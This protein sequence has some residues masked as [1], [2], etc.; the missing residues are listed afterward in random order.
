MKKLLCVLLVLCMAFM[1]SVTAMAEYEQGSARDEFGD[2]VSLVKPQNLKDFVNTALSSDGRFL[3]TDYAE[4][5]C[6]K[7]SVKVGQPVLLKAQS[8]DGEYSFSHWETAGGTFLSENPTLEYTFKSGERLNAVYKT[9]LLWDLNFED[10]R[11]TVPTDRQNIMQVVSVDGNRVMQYAPT[12]T[13]AITWFTYMGNDQNNVY[14]MTRLKA[15][16]DYEFTFDYYIEN[17]GSNPDDIL[18]IAPHNDFVKQTTPIIRLS[19]ETGRWTRWMPMYFRTDST[20]GAG[21]SDISDGLFQICAGKDFRIYIDNVRLKKVTV[22]DNTAAENP[23]TIS[24]YATYGNFIKLPSNLSVA[25]LR[26]A[27][28]KPY[29]VCVSSAGVE[30]EPNDSLNNGMK[31]QN[32]DDEK[33]VAIDGDLNKDGKVSVT[34]IVSAVDAILKGT[35]DEE[36]VFLSDQ[37]RDDRLSVT[38]LVS[39]RAQILNPNDAPPFKTDESV[40]YPILKYLDYLTVN[41]RYSEYMSGISFY[42]GGMSLEFS[43]YCKGD[44]KVRLL[45]GKSNSRF[46]VYVDGNRVADLAMPENNG[47]L[48]LSKG[49]K[50]GFH[51]FKVALQDETSNNVVNLGELKIEGQLLPHKTVDQRLK[52][53]VIGDSITAGCG[54]L[55]P[56]YRGNGAA[57][58]YAYKTAE[59]LGARLS[60]FA[61]GGRTLCPAP[62]RESIAQLYPYLQPWYGRT[63]NTDTYNTK[64]YDFKEKAD[65]IV[66]NLGTN[67]RTSEVG[68]ETYAENMRSFLKTLKEKNLQSKIVWC[69]GMMYTGDMDYSETI[70]AVL[71]EFGGSEKGY[72]ACALPYDRGGVYTY[73][74]KD[75]NTR[76]VPSV[77]EK[78][79]YYSHPNTEGHAAAAEVLTAFLKEQ[80]LKK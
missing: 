31:I 32:G 41:G 24:R 44:V 58:T 19:G 12:S 74:D 1:D 79:H 9:D 15:N 30:N 28:K 71:S 3:K 8:T 62:G 33:T 64:A 50:E 73:T 59:A 43:A 47:D 4:I 78:D 13:W 63:R 46:A 29:A 36:T 25:A 76:S 61:V 48:Y 7:T 6:S 14:R 22:T 66:V 80:V 16:T 20:V 69:Y 40:T 26:M 52:I 38:D 11:I 56:G 67:D 77:S 70:V 18:G 2:E 53:E 37:N 49:L 17:A 45:S 65:V 68:E 42:Y 23:E 60:T 10:N 5:L 75:G 35:A 34:D 54:T 72:Y 55:F 57:D 21:Y 39:L 51:S 27:F